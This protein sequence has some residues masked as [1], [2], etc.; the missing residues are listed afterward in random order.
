MDRPGAILVTTT[1]RHSQ[2]WTSADR[3]VTVIVAKTRV[4]LSD[5]KTPF[6]PFCDPCAVLTIAVPAVAE[7]PLTATF[8]T[9]MLGS[10]PVIPV[11]DM[12]RLCSHVR[13]TLNDL[14]TEIGVSSARMGLE[15]RRAAART[16]S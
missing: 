16:R 3:P 4:R 5:A 1:S 10:T 9:D 14:V 15:H 13:T 12:R 2:E 8:G 6:V 7:S 11:R